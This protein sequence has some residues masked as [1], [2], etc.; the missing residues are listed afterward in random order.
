MENMKIFYGLDNFLVN[1]EV[2]NYLK[3]QDLLN[4]TTAI[5]TYYLAQDTFEIM[6]PEILQQSKIGDLFNQKKV[7]I[8]N[9]YDLILN[10]N[11]KLWT[12]FSQDLK[13]NLNHD[14][15]IILKFL[16]NNLKQSILISPADFFIVKNYQKN[17]LKNWIKTKAGE[18][19]INLR[20]E[21]ITSIINKFPNSLN[22]IN[23]EL[24]KIACLNNQVDQ[25]LIE[26][27][28]SKYFIKNP[29]QLI[30]FWLTKDFQSFWWQYRNFWEKIN[31]DKVNL[32]N[33]LIYQLELIRNIK[34]LLIKNVSYQEIMVTLKISQIQMN[35]LLKSQLEL[36][37]VNQL[38]VKA[39]ELDL[40]IKTG[41]IA[42]N[43]AFD[44]FFGRN[45]V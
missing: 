21:L 4:Q 17:Q 15:I 44:L 6:V 33:I 1:Q 3:E 42:K 30:N 25:N 26:K 34:L 35:S 10:N 19:Q 9:D 11:L 22:V 13:N 32:F 16:T 38:L 20:Q 27:F 14:V 24:K 37:I 18:Y 41:K 23:N 8:I 36:K 28:A 12:K 5:N 2:N 31:Y 43:L 7:L 29:Y 39:H 45:W 40:Q